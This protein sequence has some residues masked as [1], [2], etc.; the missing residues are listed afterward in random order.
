[1]ID[2]IYFKQVP[3]NGALKKKEVISGIC[4]H[5]SVKRELANGVNS[6]FT[7]N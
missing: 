6:Y 5:I 1:M 7:P 3:R 2:D 4:I